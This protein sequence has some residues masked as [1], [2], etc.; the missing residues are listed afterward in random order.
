[1]IRPKTR[2]ILETDNY[3]LV[4]SAQH[5]AAELGLPPLMAR[6]L[7][8]RGVT[9]LEQAKSFLYGGV[10]EL[11]DPF[12]LKGMDAAIKRIR[13]AQD[14]GENI[15]IFGDYDADGISGTSLMIH[16]FH[17]L[18]LNFDYYIPHRQLE[19]YGL[20]NQAIEK[21]AEAGV[22]LI[23][24]VDTGISAVE[25]IAYARS[26]HIDVV[27]TDHHE[28][29]ETLPDAVAIINPKQVD[30]PYPFK[31]L[32]GAGVAFK[33][34]QAL[35]GRPPLEWAEIATIGTIADL[36]P[37]TGENRC[38]VREGLKQMAAT[39][40]TGIR[41]LAEVADI[42][43]AN[44]NS[45]Q[46]A[47]GMAPRINASGRLA[48]ADL[49]VQLLTTEN[50]EEALAAAVRLDALN[51]ERQQMVEGIIQEAEQQLEERAAAGE[52][53]ERPTVTVAAK[54]GWNVGVIGI[55]ASKLI[56]KQYRPAL[57][58]GINPETGIC[59]GS[60]R[61]IDGF[62]LYRALRE[63]DDLLMHYGGHQAAAGMTLHRDQLPELERRLGVL[64][65]EWLTADEWQRRTKIDGECL[66]EEADLSTIAQLELLE[67]FGV[68]NPKPR[69]LLREVVVE[70][71]RAMGKEGRHLRLTLQ[72][73]G[74]RLEAVGFGEGAIAGRLGAGAV[75]DVIGELSVNEWNGS[76]KPQLMLSDLKVEQIQL[77]DYRNDRYPEETLERLL[78]DRSRQLS[79]E[80]T[81]IVLLREGQ[82]FAESAAA[83]EQA[84][85]QQGPR[86]VFKDY[87]TFSAP[88]YCRELILFH[89]PPSAAELADTIGYCRELGAVTAL[90]SIDRRHRAGFPE[91]EHFG[92][93]YQLLRQM[94]VEELNDTELPARLS[95]R[96]G[97]ATDIVALMLGVF[98]ELEFIAVREGGIKVNPA[99]RKREL[100]ES[101]AYQA[102]QE[103]IQEN[104][105]LFA[106]A[107][108]LSAWI[109]KQIKS[110]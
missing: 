56:E 57:V 29:P 103:A 83:A 95:V 102:G 107:A 39:S 94:S 90:Y 36:M 54:E 69:M 12:L 25:Q 19:G 105:L 18:G 72:Q 6:L 68:G 109:N 13:L 79:A 33:L 27:V 4:Q 49:A 2:W 34:G 22:S 3:E 40:N 61:S 55:V 74:K 70:E 17:K 92:K 23:V 71:A 21:A 16:L 86:I 77:F 42:E 82:A 7:V 24:T 8:Q 26:L 78:K 51:K 35:L 98:E 65:D 100:S 38:L 1:M 97:W 48:H 96:I 28:P 91:R 106:A 99:P 75:A 58:F 66:L 93:V 64:A 62:D 14:R 110:V 32:A 73:Q 50:A 80:D 44:V 5:L 81:I 47:F 11:H 60:A 85:P 67:P 76:R 30:C 41:A 87:Q 53:P 46:V 31:G 9:S 101:S 37:L 84:V 88:E 45:T 43:L 20:N 108:D 52:M 59:K 15:R 104:R 10:E 89:C 63:C